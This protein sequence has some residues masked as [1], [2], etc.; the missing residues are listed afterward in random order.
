MCGNHSQCQ[1]PWDLQ[2]ARFKASMIC[3]GFSEYSGLVDPEIAVGK[4]TKQKN[5]S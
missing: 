3:V 1:R 5:E 4:A 2:R